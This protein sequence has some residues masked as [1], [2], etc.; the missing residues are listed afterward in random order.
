MKIEFRKI[1]FEAKKFSFTS[2]SVIFEGNFGRITSSLVKF[3]A[4]MSGKIPSSC[5]KCGQD[6]NLDIDE[7]IDYI[8]SDG[9]YSDDKYEETVIEVDDNIID[10]NQ[11][12][13]SEIIS[14]NSDYHICK[15]CN[16]DELFE[17]EL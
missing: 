15:N 9:I 6:I 11:L 14:I 2:N 17:Q 8:V 4:K 3:N 13:D 7:S 10:F 1:P 16:I 12:I 5:Y